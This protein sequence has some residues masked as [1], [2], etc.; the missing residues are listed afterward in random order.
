[1]ELIISPSG[2]ISRYELANQI[3]D[4]VKFEID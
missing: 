4:I 2:E 3:I 1:M